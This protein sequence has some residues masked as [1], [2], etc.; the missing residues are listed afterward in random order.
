MIYNIILLYGHCFEEILI[1]FKRPPFYYIRGG[2][3]AGEIDYTVGILAID[4]ISYE[5]NSSGWNDYTTRC[6]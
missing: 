3:E 4:I 6:G 2:F 5:E 1:R